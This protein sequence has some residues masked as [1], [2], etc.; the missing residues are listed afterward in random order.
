MSRVVSVIDPAGG[1][2]FSFCPLKLLYPPP[3]LR[4]PHVLDYTTITVGSAG[5]RQ[6]DSSKCFRSS[7]G[8]GF[9]WS[10]IVA[11]VA[12]LNLMVDRGG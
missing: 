1:L 9:A 11:N 2:F 8:S 7:L 6:R 4:E 5:V 12:P 3:I 10:Y